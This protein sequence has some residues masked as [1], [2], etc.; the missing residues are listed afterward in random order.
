MAEYLE[1][2]EQLDE[3]FELGGLYYVFEL[4]RSCN[5]RREGQGEGQQAAEFQPAMLL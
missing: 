1:D 4:M 2:F 5:R 3:V